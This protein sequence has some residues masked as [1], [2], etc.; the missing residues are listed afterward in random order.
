MNTGTTE[1]LTMISRDI[2]TYTGKR[3]DNVTA[4]IR[5]ML[6]QLGKDVLSF[7]EMSADIYGRP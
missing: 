2:A 3:H 6:E 7:Q 1:P 4:D 5:N